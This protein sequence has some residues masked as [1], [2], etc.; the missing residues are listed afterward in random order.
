MIVMRMRWEGATPENY[1]AM[2][3]K[4]DWEKNPPD[5]GVQHV[6]WFDGTGMNIVDVW[7]SEE[8]FNAFIQ[9][10]VMP[11]VQELGIP[12]QPEVQIDQ[13]HAVNE[14]LLARR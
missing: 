9:G 10:Q 4:L 8:K 7:E 11:A 12:G 3:D 14:G 5:G 13:A 1:D 2:A 6:A